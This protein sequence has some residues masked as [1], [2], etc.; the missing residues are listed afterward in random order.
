MKKLRIHSMRT[1]MFLAGALFFSAG[2][3]TVSYAQFAIDPPVNVFELIHGQTW[4]EPV[5]VTI[6]SDTVIA[7]L[8]LLADTTGS[9][10][11]A[12][13]NAQTSANEI[14]SDLLGLGFANVRIGVG[15]YKDF[16]FPSDPY[17]FD[18][19][20]SLSNVQ[21][22]I[23]A[24]IG[25]WSASGGG[26]GSEG[27]FFALDRL[28]QDID[29][30]GGTIGWRNDADI[31]IIV[32]FGDAPAHD[33]VCAA[34]SGLG[35]DINEASVID[36]LQD[37]NKTVIAIGTT[38]GYPD[39]LNDNPSL[40][41][42]SYSGTC[43]VINGSPEQADRIA[44]QTGG[45][46]EQDVDPNVLANT[47]VELVKAQIAS[48]D[49][50]CLVP[51]PEIAD[52]VESIVPD[53]YYNVD[54]EFQ[55]T[56]DFTVNWLGVKE[57]LLFEDQVFNGNLFVAVTDDDVYTV[58]AEKPVTITVPHCLPVP[59]D[60]HPTSCPN[61]LNLKSNGVVPVA[62]LGTD[63][64]PAE[65]IEPQSAFLNGVYL[66][67]YAYEDVATPYLPY[68]E[69][70]LTCYDCNTFGADG[71]MD[72]TYKFKTQE[73]VGSIGDVEDG[74]CLRLELRARLKNTDPVPEG[75]RGRV[76]AGHDVVI[77]KNKGN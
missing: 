26:D 50:V 73:I 63:E 38:T 77:I 30:A 36:V 58:E 28:A 72:L 3:C 2:F 53:C 76:V 1:M 41:A 23:V 14:V 56:L 49:Q 25:A 19:Q 33:P 32:W 42:W 61:P 35:Y 8:Y 47:I 52:F 17:A 43:D 59:V 6:G 45:I 68:D 60:I 48:L 29:P 70:K 10:G 74:A 44:G 20:L 9:M 62:I 15:N 27:Q 64:I 13:S 31:Q 55:T 21:A 66:L 75:L 51:S 40:D 5:S 37:N 12:I 24:A 4:A 22:D 46:S 7:D 16:P 57:C 11:S 34:I 54:L 67:R 65:W 39:A 69:P 71:L 18:H